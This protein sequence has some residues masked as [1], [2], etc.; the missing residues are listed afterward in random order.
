MT[1]PAYVEHAVIVPGHV[2]VIYRKVLDSPKVR[3]VLDRLADPDEMAVR[4][5]MRRAAR[6]YG[7]ARF[8][9]EAADS[10]DGASWPH[11]PIGTSEAAEL[12]GLTRRRVQQLAA[13]G[14]GHRDATGRWCLDRDEIERMTR[15][16]A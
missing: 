10:R 7:Q 3:A 1:G 14:L 11:D 6:A 9:A 15:R 12:L 13:G 8:A 16:A 2:A 4:E 5:A